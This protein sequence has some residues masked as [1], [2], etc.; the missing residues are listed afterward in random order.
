MRKKSRLSSLLGD[1]AIALCVATLAGLAVLLI[2]LTVH[3]PA[4]SVSHTVTSAYHWYYKPRTDGQQPVL[5]DNAP[6]VADYKNVYAIGNANEKS[7]Y[8]TF[9]AGY[10]NGN[11]ALILDTLKKAGAPAAFFVTGHFVK[12][13]PALVKRMVSEGHLVCNHT[14]THKDLT[15]LSRSEF[16]KELNDLSAAYEALIGFPMPKFVR[17]PEGTYSEEC[18]KTAD[19]LGYKVVFWSFAYKDWLNDDQPS[20]ESAKQTML[21]RTHPGAI[22]LLHSNSAT[23]AKVLGDVIAAWQA[24]GYTLKS[25]TDFSA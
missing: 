25:L 15:T 9:D 11:T 7:L 19:S 18:L 10:D 13:N 6:F 16:E 20:P 14:A 22:L 4:T 8:L 3:P 23:N 21:S 5:A 1:C 17:P 2:S 12:S 24:E